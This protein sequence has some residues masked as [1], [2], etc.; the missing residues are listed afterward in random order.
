VSKPLEEIE[1]ELWA[2]GRKRVHPAPASENLDRFF[3][4]VLARQE[5]RRY[6]EEWPARRI[7]LMEPRRRLND[8]LERLQK[9]EKANF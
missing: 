6:R 8:Q 9:H 7:E 3:E 1:A 2:D 4:E 5:E